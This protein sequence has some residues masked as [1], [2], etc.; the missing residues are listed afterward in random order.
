MSHNILTSTRDFVN[1]MALP[2]NDTIVQLAQ[3][4]IEPVAEKEEVET[5]AET[6][7]M[8]GGTSLSLLVADAV[9][10]INMDVDMIIDLGD[11]VEVGGTGLVLGDNPVFMNIEEIRHRHVTAFEIVSFHNGYSY[12]LTT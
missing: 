11:A 7:N 5:G 6:W 4:M 10:R 8:A 1:L 2:L 3:K 9:A 12:S